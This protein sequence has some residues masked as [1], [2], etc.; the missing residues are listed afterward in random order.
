VIS[1]YHDRNTPARKILLAVLGAVLALISLIVTAF[2]ASWPEGTLAAILQPTHT[3]TPT[4]T[5]MPTCTNTPLPLPTATHSPSPTPTVAEPQAHQ[6]LERP[7]SEEQYNEPTRYY[8]YGSTAGGKYRIHRGADFPG[9]FGTPIFAA[10]RGRVII[11]GEDARVIYGERLGFYGQLVVIQLLEQYRGQK[12]YVLYGHLSQVYVHFLQEV[13]AGDLIGEVGMSGVA[14]GPHLHLE[15]RLGSN[16]YQD[17]RNPELWLR[18]LP[19]RGTLLG[20]L[21]DVEGRPIAS[22]PL[23]LYRV[24]GE[25][26][27][28]QDATTYPASDVNADDEWKENFA[29]GDVPAGDYVV[30]TYVNGHLYT[31]EFTIREGDTTYVIIE[32]P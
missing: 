2:L 9:V 16:S 22:H 27:R 11:A 26:R 14:I 4:L 32:A 3:P 13:E 7:F 21:V 23:T 6:W 18:P 1:D 10:A 30:K 24:E 29:W 17:T 20:R 15:V 5:P 8:P 28:W 19:G 25:E 12:V 31:E